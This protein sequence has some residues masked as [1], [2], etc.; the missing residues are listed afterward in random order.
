[1]LYNLMVW[2]LINLVKTLG[3][4]MAEKMGAGKSLFDA[5]MNEEQ[6]RVQQV[7]E[8]YGEAICMREG[9][10]LKGDKNYAHLDKIFRLFASKSL[11]PYLGWFLAQGFISQ[12][13]VVV[14]QDSIVAL[15]KEIAAIAT[16][17][18]DGFGIPEHLITMPMAGD[19]EKYND[20]PNKGELVFSKL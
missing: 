17:I 5:W 4:N 7:A 1:M 3:K 14:F 8:I 12:Q 13:A 20:G 9:L 11:E 18:V 15:N 6:H 2:R 16:D 19:Y 10:K